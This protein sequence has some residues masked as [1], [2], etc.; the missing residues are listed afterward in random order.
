MCNCV[1]GVELEGGVGSG[2]K[3]RRRGGGREGERRRKGGWD[4]LLLPPLH[5][6]L[7]LGL[8]LQSHHLRSNPPG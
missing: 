1:P 3:G 7:D 8:H 6:G 4:V 2:G 5:L